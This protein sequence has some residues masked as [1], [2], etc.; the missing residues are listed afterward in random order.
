MG[1][2]SVS[3]LPSRR[4]SWFVVASLVL[5]AGCAGTDTAPSG[6]TAG[7]N[8]R[9]FQGATLRV[10]LTNTPWQGAIAKYIP[11]FTELTGI[12]VKVEVLSQDQLWKTLETDLRTPGWV[13]VFA[14]IPNLDGLHYMN[15]GYTRS[16]N[17]YLRN[18]R[19]TPGTYSWEDF[20]PKFREA[21]QVRGAIL[22]PPVMAENMALLYR[23]D[24]FSRYQVGVPRTLDELEAAARFLHKKAMSPQGAS[25]VGLVSRGQGAAATA[26][27]AS[28]LHSF[29]GTWLDGRG[30]P[31]LDGPQ[32]LEALQWMS[33]VFGQ[34]APPDISR[35]GWQEA[36]ALF[37]DGRAAMYI[38][39]SS[40]YPLIEDSKSRVADRVGYAQFPSGPAGFGAT[41]AVRGLAIAKQSAA[42]EAAW[43]FMQWASGPE[44]VRKALMHGVLVAR[45]STWKDRVARGEVPSDLAE[46]LQQAGRTGRVDWLPPLVAVTSAREVVGRVITAALQGGNI[47]EAADHANRELEEIISKTE[48]PSTTTPR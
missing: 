42:P 40:I 35:F 17:E 4:A 7:F 20:F 26:L 22:G 38:E 6:P 36:S 39:G 24:V 25:G 8:W 21:M 15:A 37:L 3:R 11:E 16:V 9:Q 33:R 28:L 44:M 29:G 23:K 10:L 34:S 27:Y 47:R 41:V 46:S 30:R 32:S 31:A 18:P 12:R 13:D 14:V 43:L 19:L 5:L 48:R 2:R 1:F 45:E